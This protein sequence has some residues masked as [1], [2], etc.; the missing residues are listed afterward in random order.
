MTQSRINEKLQQDLRNL[1]LKYSKL[2]S[3]EK[4]GT[5]QNY[6]SNAVEFNLSSTINSSFLDSSS[7]IRLD[8]QF[9]FYG[10]EVHMEVL[11]AYLDAFH[12]I[13]IDNGCFFDEHKLKHYDF[14]YR[15]DFL[16]FSHHCP[17]LSEYYINGQ[18][19]EMELIFNLA[20]SK[21]VKDEEFLFENL[22]CN[23][24]FFNMAISVPIF[25]SIEYQESLKMCRLHGRV[26]RLLP[27]TKLPYKRLYSCKS[28]S[29]RNRTMITLRPQ[30]SKSKLII[31]QEFNCFEQFM[32]STVSEMKCI[33]CVAKLEESISERWYTNR[34]A[35]L[36]SVN[37]GLYL[38]N[39]LVYF[40]DDQFNSINLLDNLIMYGFVEKTNIEGAAFGKKKKYLGI[41]H[42]YALKICAIEKCN[43]V[44]KNLFPFIHAN[45]GKLLK[46][47]L[48]CCTAYP[49]VNN[50]SLLVR[51]TCKSEEQ[52]HL[53]FFL[54]NMATFD[55]RNYSKVQLE[56]FVQYQGSNVV[57]FNPT[58]KWSF[59]LMDQLSCSNI[60]MCIIWIDIDCVCKEYDLDLLRLKSIY[61]PLKIENLDD[62]D[63]IFPDLMIQ[64]DTDADICEE[65]SFEFTLNDN[66]TLEFSKALATVL[67][68]NLNDYVVANIH[69][70]MNVAKNQPI[71]MLKCSLC[72][73]YY[74]EPY[75]NPEQHRSSLREYFQIT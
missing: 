71:D 66:L 75:C 4:T 70:L 18:H 32:V 42:R 48:S 65:T 69:Y 10:L 63:F 13:E 61:F 45:Y 27:L 41:S 40:D 3:N 44:P 15:I 62:C 2:E 74:G 51:F 16:K 64:H 49:L 58:K 23:V 25:R 54:R 43:K 73:H 60:Q 1:M 31:R 33:S 28:D 21:F 9:E 56:E 46:I 34:Q 57:F 47:I 38:Q 72:E 52:Y 22:K 5:E 26:V 14:K 37:A 50:K 59:N 7:T 68:C 35:A 55:E 39:A 12:R 24:T 8:E 36:V 53:R 29:C 17:A 11:V 20:S 19:K 6:D 67:D 30:I